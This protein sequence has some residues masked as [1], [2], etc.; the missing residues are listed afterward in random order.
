M[1]YFF[2]HFGSALSHLQTMI[3]YKSN[4]L[5]VLCCVGWS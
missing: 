4:I 2:G 5:R 1:M 3:E